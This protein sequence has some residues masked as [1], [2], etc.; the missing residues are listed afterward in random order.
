MGVKVRLRGEKWYV[1]IDCHGGRK[2][3]CVGARE[4]AEKVKRELEARL[5]LGD[6]GIFREP[7]KAEALQAYAERWLE[8]D[9]PRECKSST[10][11]FYRDYQKRY[12]R[13]R[14]GPVEITKITRDAVKDFIAD[15]GRKGLARNTIRLAVASLRV[16]LSAAVED[17]L[18]S[19]N[20]AA[21]LGRFV[22]T[23]QPEHSAVAMEPE[24]VDRFLAAT[25]EFCPE[26]YALFLI[27]VRTGLRQGEILGLK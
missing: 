1:V 21:K 12:V 7:Q 24:E 9:A 20:P 5:A 16:I 18:I 8:T 19:S 26:Y 27:A 25:R 6:L 2:S 3:K 14:F 11:D 17:G 10:V 15:L 23:D 4:A 22:E 13:C